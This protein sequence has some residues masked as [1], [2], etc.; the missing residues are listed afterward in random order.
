MLVAHSA[1]EL[2][3]TRTLL[4]LYINPLIECLIRHKGYPFD[5][6]S[7]QLQLLIDIKTD[8]IATLQALVET[9]RKYDVLMN[10]HQIK[11][12]ITGKRPD[13]SL[14]TA[15][16]PFITF[17]G[18]LDKTYSPGALTKIAMLSD[19]GRKYTKWDGTS[20]LPAADLRKMRTAVAK[21]HKLHKPV[22]FGSVN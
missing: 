6:T 14:F 17:D 16:P 21:A 5:D 9:I 22:R 20:K 11:W 15:Y 10:S 12:V 3:A 8:F 18:E 19:D 1:K 2:T 13:Q 4:N 7:K